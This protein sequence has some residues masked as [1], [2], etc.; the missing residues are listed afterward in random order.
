LKDGKSGRTPLF[1]ALDN[2]HT[3]VAQTL[4]KA[5]AIANIANYAGQTALPIMTETKSAPFR[6][7]T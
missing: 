6:V 7:A 5:G 3:L 2:K 1:H 4:L